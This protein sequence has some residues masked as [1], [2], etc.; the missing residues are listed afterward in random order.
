[1]KKHVVKKHVVRKHWARGNHVPAWQ[2]DRVVRDYGRY[3]LHRPAHGQRW[4]RVDNDF[5]LISIASGVIAGL[6]AAH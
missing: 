2:R 6:I 3:G 1:M 4:I 5:L